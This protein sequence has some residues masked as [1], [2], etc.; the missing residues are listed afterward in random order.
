MLST[1]PP[2]FSGGISEP[3]PTPTH[4]EVLLDDVHLDLVE[5]VD[6]LLLGELVAVDALRLMHPEAHQV[7]GLGEAVVAAEEEPLEHVGQVAQVEDVVELDGRGQEHLGALV[8]HGQRGRHHVVHQP[9]DGRVEAVLRVGEV[10]RQDLR[11]D[12]AERLVVR[13]AGTQRKAQSQS[14]DPASNARAHSSEK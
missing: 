9:P 11:V 8:V 7:G 4:V 6:V 13:E 3:T 5:G 2:F 1:P 14:G 10:L 12:G